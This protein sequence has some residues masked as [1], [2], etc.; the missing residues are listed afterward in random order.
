M[1]L[2]GPQPLGAV[3]TLDPDVRELLGRH[4][5]PVFGHEAQRMPP[6]CR[7]LLLG[8]AA[9]GAGRAGGDGGAGAVDISGGCGAVSRDA[10]GIDPVALL[11]EL[12]M[13]SSERAA[14]ERG[15]ASRTAVL[16]VPAVLNAV[17]CEVLRAAVD[18]EWREAPD[19]VDGAPDIQLNLT[20]QRLTDLV[21][22]AATA[23]LMR[24]PAAFVAQ[25]EPGVLAPAS[26]GEGLSPCDSS[27]PP[28]QPPTAHPEDADSA[29]VESALTDDATQIFV[30]RYT[31]AERP[32]NPFHIDGSAMTVNCALGDDASFSGGK[33]LACFDHK[34]R[35]VAWLPSTSI[36]ALDGG[37]RGGVFVPHEYSDTSS[38]LCF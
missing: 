4:L 20:L 28:P 30:R 26:R 10:S 35:L 8:G 27:R 21:G 1:A 9:N 22:D 37:C 36:R 33:L 38:Q 2:V 3:A 6:L 25:A 31:P 17:Q 15:L 16:Q 5:L 11:E 24:L 23:A 12:G 32:W 19:T 13:A 18:A 34:V 29:A 14:A 7:A